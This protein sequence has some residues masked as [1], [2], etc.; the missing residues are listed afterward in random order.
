MSQM[1]TIDGRW[2]RADVSVEIA[3]SFTPSAAL[4]AMSTGSCRSETRMVS[5]VA[6][7]SPETAIGSAAGSYARMV[8]ATN[9]AKT[10]ASAPQETT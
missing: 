8:V 2:L 10:S 1:A 5:V 7:L 3:R 6:E 4:S 9:I